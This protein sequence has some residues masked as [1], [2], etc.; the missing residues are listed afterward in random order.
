MSLLVK[1]VVVDI[2]KLLGCL[3]RLCILHCC[4]LYQIQT[5]MI[6]KRSISSIHLLDT[7]TLGCISGLLKC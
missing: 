7:W 2:D 1:S 3:P 4:I 6:N 5:H